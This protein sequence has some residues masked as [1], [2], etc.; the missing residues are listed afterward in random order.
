[1]KANTKWW[2]NLILILVIK[3]V[4]VGKTNL[5]TPSWTVR[6]MCIKFLCYFLVEFVENHIIIAHP[7]LPNINQ[8]NFGAS[9]WGS[10]FMKDTR[11]TRIYKRFFMN[12]E[13]RVSSFDQQHSNWPRILPRSFYHQTGLLNKSEYTQFVA[14]PRFWS[15]N[16]I[17]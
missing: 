7:K 6:V 1:M 14:S 16:A 12:K 3:K 2:S 8:R 9:W 4:W 17:Y 13:V 5:A 10:N 15:F 11:I